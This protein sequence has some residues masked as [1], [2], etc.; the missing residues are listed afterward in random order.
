MT[1]INDCTCTLWSACNRKQTSERGNKRYYV[2]RKEKWEP[3]RETALIRAEQKGFA[4]KFCSERYK[5]RE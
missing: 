5:A 1:P 3:A 2:Y 4:E